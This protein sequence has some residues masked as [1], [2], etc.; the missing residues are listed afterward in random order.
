MKDK[1]L[2]HACVLNLTDVCN[3]YSGELRACDRQYSNFSTPESVERNIQA[4]APSAKQ[5]IIAWGCKEI[6]KPLIENCKIVLRAM[7]AIQVYGYNQLSDTKNLYYYHPLK[8]GGDWLDG[9]RAVNW[10]RG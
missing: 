4:Y 6:F 1:N 9:L 3:Q 8:R 10:E 2:K 7:G 5:V